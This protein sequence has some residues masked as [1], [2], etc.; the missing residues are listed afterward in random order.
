VGTNS[1]AGRAGSKVEVDRK[2]A[3]VLHARRDCLL[4]APRLLYWLPGALMGVSIF[5][6]LHVYDLQV[7]ML[8]KGR[9]EFS[10]SLCVLAIFCAILGAL[11]QLLAIHGMQLFIRKRKLNALD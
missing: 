5:S 11:C 2:V 8:N 4:R 10:L 9:F 6:G 7:R 1:S 3:L